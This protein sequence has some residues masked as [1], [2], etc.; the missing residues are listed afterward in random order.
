MSLAEG[1][2][3]TSI[4]AGSLAGKGIDIT[5]SSVSGYLDVLAGLGLVDKVE[6][7][8]AR[9]RAR[10]YYRL[11][12]PVLSLMF[13]AE[14]KYN[15]SVTERVGELPLGR[16]VQFAVGELL[17]ERYDGVMAYSPYEDIDVVILKDGKPVIG[18]EVKVGEI[19]RREAERAISRI[20]SSGIPRV[21]LVSLRDKPKFE[22]EESLGPEELME[23]AD[24]IYGR[25][26]SQQGP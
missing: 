19:D 12:S 1:E 9:R 8:G 25:V 2:W 7:F 14:A 5:A 15:V 4:I 26:L 17:A 23:V 10:W 20:R 11:S 3:N 22:V 6:I 18:Y 21:G 24:E 16:E 13:Y